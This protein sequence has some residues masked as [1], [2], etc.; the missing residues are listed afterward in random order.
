[1]S[2]AEGLRWMPDHAWSINLSFIWNGLGEE[3]GRAEDFIVEIER[4]ARAPDERSGCAFSPSLSRME[5][6][7]V[8][9]ARR[10]CGATWRGRGDTMKRE[11]LTLDPR[12]IIN[13]H[14][15]SPSIAP[16]KIPKANTSHCAKKHLPSPSLTWA[17]LSH[18]PDS[19]HRFVVW[20]LMIPLLSL[21]LSLK[22]CMRKTR[23]ALHI[24]LR[25]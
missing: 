24:S 11:K 14:A 16:P 5:I 12:L 8:W 18:E 21:S 2:R 7:I 13:C 9:S 10:A 22:Y 3:R 25:W 17:C 6:R 15:F 4:R 20:K 1:M 23:A 19:R